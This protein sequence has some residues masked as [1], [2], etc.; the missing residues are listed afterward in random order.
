M[1]GDLLGEV[2]V[3]SFYEIWEKKYNG[4]GDCWECPGLAV[5]K[6]NN[7]REQNNNNRRNQDESSHT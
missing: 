4:C 5:C 3:L 1:P 6:K 2:D 7:S